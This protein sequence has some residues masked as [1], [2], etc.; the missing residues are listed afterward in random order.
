MAGSASFEESVGDR[1][2]AN[3]AVSE[4]SG[5]PVIG[6]ND[7]GHEDS[8]SGSD[9]TNAALL[10]KTLQVWQVRNSGFSTPTWS[11]LER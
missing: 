2:N 9:C 10:V 6:V 11:N 5:D 4:R 7:G 3:D 1:E 8:G